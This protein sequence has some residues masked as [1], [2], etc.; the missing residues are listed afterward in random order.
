MRIRA[1]P[2]SPTALL[3]MAAFG[4]L[5]ACSPEGD[6]GANAEASEALGSSDLRIESVSTKPYLVTG[7]DVL[8]RIEAGEDLDLSDVRVSANGTD[9]TTRFSL[10]VPGASQGASLIG[11]VDGLGLGDNQ[12]EARIPDSDAMAALEL[13]NYPIT[14]PIISG[15]H[16]TPYLCGTERFRTAG[17]ET[18]GAPLDENCSEACAQPF[19]QWHIVGVPRANIHLYN[20]VAPLFRRVVFKASTDEVKDIAVRSLNNSRIYFSDSLTETRK[21]TTVGSKT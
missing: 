4:V 2:A 11:L 21:I 19:H 6:P 18:L 12:I 1:N 3:T 17:G 8:L 10:D 7:G 13:T 15:P 14:G 9:V 20:A 16:E 5:G